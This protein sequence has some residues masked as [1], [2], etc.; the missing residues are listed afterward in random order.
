MTSKV[1]AFQDFLIRGVMK[2][3]KI[4]G[5]LWEDAHFLL[6]DVPLHRDAVKKILPLWMKPSD[7]PLATLF[8]CD[9]R[10]TAF[11]VPY[12][13]SAVLIHVRTPLG[14]GYHCCWMP[15]DDD[16]ALIYGRELLGYPKKMADIVF[17]EDGDNISA[18][19]TRRGIKVLSMEGK[20]GEAQI[21][22]PPIF[23][24][25]TFNVGG[26]GQFM[27]INPVWLFRPMEEIYESYEAEV[28]VSVEES[29]YDP[30]S[31]LVAGDAI[32]GR[33]AVIDILG[34]PYMF[35]VGLTGFIWANRTFFMRY[36]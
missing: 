18:S 21:N 27:A 29:E 26:M 35:P 3:A 30:I 31:R 32:R 6:A 20:R 33:M 4:E 14:E 36:R 17:E 7:P 16:T 2:G 8:I 13:E 11:T 23:N 25:K 22:P 10:K 9:Y 5:T 1:N 19:V 24:V 34:T 15:V 12:K 28:T